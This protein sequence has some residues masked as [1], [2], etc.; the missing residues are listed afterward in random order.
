MPCSPFKLLYYEKVFSIHRRLDLNSYH[1]RG[2][3]ASEVHHEF[4][5]KASVRRYSDSD[6]FYFRSNFNVFH[7]L[8]SR[9]PQIEKGA[10]LRAGRLVA[11]F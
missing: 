7:N 3:F 8:D 1:L 10:V 2:F 11:S 5:A 4:Y 6:F 9:T